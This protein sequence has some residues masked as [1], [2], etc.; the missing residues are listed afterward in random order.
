MVV[1]ASVVIVVSC[2]KILATSRFGLKRAAHLGSMK[3]LPFLLVLLFSAQ[4][5]FGEGSLSPLESM[6]G[7][8]F[9]PGELKQI[10][11]FE[12][13]VTLVQSYHPV[14]TMEGLTY[15]GLIC[16]KGSVTFLIPRFQGL[17]CLDF[18]GNR[19]VVESLQAHLGLQF[20]IKIG[21]ALILYVGPVEFKPIVGRFVLAGLEMQFPY[22]FSG[23][24]QVASNFDGQY[25]FIGAVD[26]GVTDSKFDL[27]LGASAGALQISERD[28]WGPI[29]ALISEKMRLREYF[30]GE[31]ELP[32]A[33]IPVPAERPP[34]VK[35]E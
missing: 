19:Y 24:A 9:T 31:R 26:L 35:V 2:S 33:P 29:E 11:R 22:L 27:P 25:L 3:R 16:G 4:S 18:S 15:K 1:S 10:E 13:Q 23:E 34:V 21:V 5:A 8:S 12:K 28:W 14:V 32:P 30:S 17:P 6:L 7:R 20:Q